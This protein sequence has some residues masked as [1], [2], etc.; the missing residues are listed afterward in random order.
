MATLKIDELDEIFWREIMLALGYDP[1][2][3]YDDFS[4]VR[5]SWP[6]TGA[7]AWGINDNVLFVK[8]FDESGQ[9]ITR[10][11]DT[12]LTDA[13]SDIN[14]EHG[15]TRVLVVSMIA[16]GPDSYDNL[17]AVKRFFA[18]GKS[19]ALRT[20]KIYIVP[21]SDVP[22]RAPEIYN[23]QWWE[24]ADLILRFNN[25]MTFEETVNAIESV[26]VITLLNTKGSEVLEHH[27]TIT[28]E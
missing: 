1:D 14:V 8:I 23:A 11:I 27:N 17:V 3:D 18:T 28:K 13:T 9:E 10:T 5:R 24:R 19:T 15:Q 20:N 12:V 26:D 21:S 7:P 16:Y 2:A 6:Q 22:R 4:P 25:L